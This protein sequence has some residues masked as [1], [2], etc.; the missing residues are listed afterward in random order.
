MYLKLKKRNWKQS[1]KKVNRMGKLKRFEIYCEIKGFFG[2][3]VRLGV[4]SCK[5]ELETKT[6]AKDWAI[7][8]YQ[9]WKEVYGLKSWENIKEELKKNGKKC[10]DDTVSKYYEK[11]VNRR[12][13]YY[14]KD[15]NIEV[16]V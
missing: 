5:N 10:D 16:N 2:D 8:F 7:K 15:L 9:D 4:V 3:I 1:D 11:E 13:T 14:V 12:M 6:I